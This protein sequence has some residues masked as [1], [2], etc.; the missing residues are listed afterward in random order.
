MTRE[1]M[2][3]NLTETLAETREYLRETSR[4]AR[5]AAEHIGKVADELTRLDA[6][7]R[8]ATKKKHGR[9]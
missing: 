1:E 3:T 5:R 7:R 8:P 4:V 9:L 6:K 2:L